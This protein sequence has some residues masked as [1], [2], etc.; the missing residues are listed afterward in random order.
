[1][2]PIDPEL[3]FFS[4]N[5]QKYSKNLEKFKIME[6]DILSW[7]GLNP[8]IRMI[9]SSPDTNIDICISGPEGYNPTHLIK[10]ISSSKFGQTSTYES[11]LHLRE[12]GLSQ[13]RSCVKMILPNTKS[14]MGH[15]PTYSS[16]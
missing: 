4:N 14:T 2:A 16:P 7:N 3:R 11:K 15:D 6:N 9:K 8:T 12:F 13:I 10:R 5:F 1:M